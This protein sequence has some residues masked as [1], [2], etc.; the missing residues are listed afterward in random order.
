MGSAL[1][2]HRSIRD[3]KK[4]PGGGRGEP[5]DFSSRLSQGGERVLHT[6]FAGALGKSAGNV[7][8]TLN[9]SKVLRTCSPFAWG[10]SVHLRGIPRVMHGL[11]KSELFGSLW[12]RGSCRASGPTKVEAL[13]RY[14]LKLVWLPFGWY[15][16]PTA[17]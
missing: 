15:L 10:K 8:A 1:V 5:R 14:V 3:W 9:E 11:V 16:K 17:S 6:R 12:S 13:Q 7:M 4:C 2:R